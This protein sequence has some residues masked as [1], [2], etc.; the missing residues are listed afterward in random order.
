MFPGPN[1]GF[2]LTLRAEPQYKVRT[3]VQERVVAVF[4]TLRK[5]ETIDASKF[6]NKLHDVWAGSVAIALAAL[7][8]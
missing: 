3:H 8:A 1:D 4:S 7:L 6:L 2:G 5:S